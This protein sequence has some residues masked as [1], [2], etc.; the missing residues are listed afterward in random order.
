MSIHSRNWL[1]RGCTYITHLNCTHLLLSTCYEEGFQHTYNLNGIPLSNRQAKQCREEGTIQLTVLTCNYVDFS[2]MKKNPALFMRY[3]NQKYMNIIVS[4]CVLSAL[5]ISTF[6]TNEIWGS[7]NRED[8]HVCLLVV[9]PYGL[10]SDTV[11]LCDSLY[12]ASLILYSWMVSI[13]TTCF[14]DQ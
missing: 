12:G 1:W 2:C 7:H 3:S 5:T 13:C 9:M 4:P 14:S 10:D 11:L 6:L 8:I